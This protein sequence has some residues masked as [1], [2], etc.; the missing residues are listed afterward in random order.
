MN[1]LDI[2][3][4]IILVF[5]LVRG[6]FRGLVV[7]IS[8]IIGIFGGI[9]GAVFYYPAA[10]QFLHRWISDTAYTN[11]IGFLLIF[12]VIF[13]L[14]GILG[15]VIKYLLNIA[16]LGWFD[17]L[18]GA[19]FGGVKGILIASVLLFALTTFLPGGT[20]LIKTS[21]LAPHVAVITE[22][23]VKIIPQNMKQ[24]FGEKYKDVKREW[25]VKN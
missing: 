12:G 9:Y 17:R 18:C 21:R 15:V 11:I 6:I 25:K 20:P 10:A 3:I 14:V 8:S 24:R 22:G 7:E 13:I 2:V 4:G 16:S 1:A 19:A 5:T 23:I